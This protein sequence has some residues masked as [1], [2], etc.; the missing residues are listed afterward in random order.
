M[1]KH[2]VI[3]AA[4]LAIAAI[5]SLV[6]LRGAPR[7]LPQYEGRILVLQGAGATFPYPQLDEWLRAFY[8]E[9]GIKVN[10]QPVGS[11]AGLSMFFQNVADFACSDP[12]LP[13]DTWKNYIGEVMQIPW[14]AGA[15]AVIYNIPELS[16]EVELRLDA[17]VLAGIYNGSIVYWDDE[18]IKRL[19][20][21]IADKLPRR[22]IIPVYRTDASGTTEI[23]TL[24][25]NKATSGAWPKQL[26]GKTVDWPVAKT[27]RGI[28]GKGSEGIV[29][30]VTQT[31]YSI[32]YVEWGY[33]LMSGV[34]VASIKNS[35]GRFV[36]PSE[37]T[38]AEAL[39]HVSVP[40]SPLDD[41]SN[42]VFESVYAP[43]DNSYPI[44]ALT[45]IILW[46]TYKD[47][48]K[49][50]ALAE[51]LKWI[52]NKG[53]NKLLPGYVAPPERVRD[54]LLEAAKILEQGSRK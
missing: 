16:R 3:V 20:P 45:H 46:K 5:A 30:I 48:S 47:P 53:Y 33:A 31:P 23:F 4:A 14:L 36:K 38:I 25:L 32:G 52:A 28:G 42:I 51:L 17:E 11:G 39:E 26:V 29:Q 7:T 37:G 12:P 15:V 9:K 24:F 50:S 2:A 35:A 34:P 41:F 1:K 6:L 18:R 27:G 44:T 40:Q 13:R 21:E 22:E 19:N 43:G 49:A 8:S 10:Y 54:L